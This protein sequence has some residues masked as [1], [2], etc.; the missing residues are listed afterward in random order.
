VFFTADMVAEK[1][2]GK[3][4]PWIFHGSEVST[5]G[6]QAIFYRIWWWG[7]SQEPSAS[8]SLISEVTQMAQK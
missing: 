4:F 1:L 6:H 5:W 2:I 8:A 7:V 3:I